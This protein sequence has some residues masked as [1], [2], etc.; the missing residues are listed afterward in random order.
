MPGWGG[1][2]IYDRGFRQKPAYF[3]LRRA[4]EGAGPRP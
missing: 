4:L 2:L 1:A 3:V